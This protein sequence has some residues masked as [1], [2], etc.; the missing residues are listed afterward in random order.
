MTGPLTCAVL[1][2]VLQIKLVGM[3]RVRF[4]TTAD[5]L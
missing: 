4:L 5:M 3:N 2:M 1:E